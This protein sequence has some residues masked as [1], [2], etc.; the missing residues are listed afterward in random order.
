MA[1]AIYENNSDIAGS[2]H[3]RSIGLWL[4]DQPITEQ[5]KNELYLMGQ[6]YGLNSQK[7]RYLRYWD[8][9]VFTLLTHIW[10][11]EQKLQIY[12]LGIPHVHYMNL[13]NVITKMTLPTPNDVAFANDQNI[14]ERLKPLPFRFSQQQWQL[15]EQVEWINM[16]IRQL[17]GQI[18]IT[19][20][21]YQVILSHVKYMQ[22]NAQSR[23]NTVAKI[24]N[25]LDSLKSSV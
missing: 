18:V 10:T 17:K 3:G 13:N 9:R 11:A 14:L 21:V 19:E 8:P 7:R 25:E 12:E 24:A 23:A 4:F 6:A 22:P 20:Q 16:I 5:L 2:P 15:L 1:L